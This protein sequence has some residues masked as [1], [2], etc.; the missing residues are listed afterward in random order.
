MANVPLMKL[1]P[2]S[3][4]RSETFEIISKTTDTLTVDDERIKIA[5]PLDRVTLAPETLDLMTEKTIMMTIQ[6]KS[7]A[8]VK[9]EPTK[10]RHT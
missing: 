7:M 1:L 8:L 4:G 10:L 3:R 9:T 6:T 5:V 2:K